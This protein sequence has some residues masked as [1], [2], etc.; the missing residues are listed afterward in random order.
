MS[1]RCREFTGMTLGK[2]VAGERVRVADGRT[3]VE[4]GFKSAPSA[5]FPADD[6]AFSRE[7]VHCQGINVMRYSRLL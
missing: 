3:A 6:Q 1:T 4:D 2:P 5:S 7:L